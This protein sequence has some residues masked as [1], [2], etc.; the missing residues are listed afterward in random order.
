V[1][2]KRRSDEDNAPDMMLEKTLHTPKKMKLTSTGRYIYRVLFKEGNN[3]DF[4]VIALGKPWKL[5]KLYL[6]QSPYFTSMFSGAWRE[7]EQGK[8]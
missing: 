4:T 7:S 5:H 2:R 3:S 8:R 6:C 1:S